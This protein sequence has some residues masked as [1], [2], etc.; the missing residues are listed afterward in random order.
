MHFIRK[1]GNGQGVTTKEIPALEA[2]HRTLFCKQGRIDISATKCA[3]IDYANSTLEKKEA[4]GDIYIECKRGEKCFYTDGTKYY[5][6][7]CG[8]GYNAEGK[9]YCPVPNK[10][11][12]DDWFERVKIQAEQT[13]NKCHSINRFKC[14]LTDTIEEYKRTRTTATKTIEA[15]LFHNAPPCVYQVFG[16]YS[17]ITYNLYIL[18]VLIFILF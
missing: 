15:H 12:E 7:P 13:N 14:Y 8:C 1:S 18:C 16:V 2:T 4:T 10:Y 3:V 6:S 17:Y 11:N 9:G 5:K